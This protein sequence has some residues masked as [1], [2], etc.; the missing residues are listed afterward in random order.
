MRI[1]CRSSFGA[2]PFADWLGWVA[3][4]QAQHVSLDAARVE[5]LVGAGHGQRHGDP[6]PRQGPVMRWQAPLFGLVIYAAAARSRSRPPACSTLAWRSASGGRLR[7]AEAQGSLWAGSGWIEVREAGG[8]AGRR[9]A[10]RMARAARVAAARAPDGRDPASSAPSGRFCSPF[11]SRASRSPTPASTCRPPRSASGCR[12]WRRFASP[13]T[14]GSTSRACPSS[15]AA[16]RATPRCAGAR[17]A[18][19]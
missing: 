19:R 3:A 4:L 12:S 10:R 8:G 17:R 16:R 7:L 5:A 11:R 2:V 15:A 9:Q 1:M 18:P 13:A 6:R 14:C